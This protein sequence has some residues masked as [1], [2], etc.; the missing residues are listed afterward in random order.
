MTTDEFCKICQ[1]EG[2]EL[3]KEFYSYQYY[4]AIDW[5]TNS[6]LQ[7]VR[8]FSDTTQ[9]V[10]YEARS[11]LKKERMYLTIVTALRL[12]AQIIPELLVKENKELK[13]YTALI[14]GLPFFPFSRFVDKY[15]KRKAREEWDK[16]KYD[17]NGSEMALYLKRN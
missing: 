4:G 9:A 8:M 11:K 16:R 14:V 12:P 17:R 1:T 3:E 15:W 7:F 6:G 2:F 10:N 5:I 13:H